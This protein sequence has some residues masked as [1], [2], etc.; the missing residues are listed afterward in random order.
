MADIS[1]E[2][3]R[4]IHELKAGVEYEGRPGNHMFPLVRGTFKKLIQDEDGD[5]LA[6][7]D[8]MRTGPTEYTLTPN[9]YPPEDVAIVNGLYTFFPLRIEAT[10]K[11]ERNLV[12]MTT[13][14]EKR[15]VVRGL[16][17]SVLVPD[18]VNLIGEMVTGVRR[19]PVKK[20]KTAGRLTRGRRVHKKG[21]THKKNSRK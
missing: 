7:F 9:T 16:R 8:P 11:F 18:T 5:D 14:R 17:S 21:L 6:V 2:P 3:L 19:K 20:N 13:A 1:K 4:D 15:E 12:G 10:K